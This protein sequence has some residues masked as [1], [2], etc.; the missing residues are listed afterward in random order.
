MGTCSSSILL[1]VMGVIYDRIL[2]AEKMQ[3]QMCI[4]IIRAERWALREK[5]RIDIENTNINDQL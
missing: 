2:A 1:I 5:A 4:E 3:C